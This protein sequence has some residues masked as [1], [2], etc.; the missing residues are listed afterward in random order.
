MISKKPTAI[1]IGAGFTGIATAYDLAMRGFT[2]DVLERGELG[3]GTS[4][5][6]HGLLH[7]GAR[8]CVHDQESA[9]ECIVENN[10]LRKIARQCIEA[11]A[12]YFIALNES[13]EE[14]AELFIR[15]ARDCALPYKEVTPKGLLMVEPQVTP[16]IRRAFCVQD[17]TFDPLRLTY[18]FAA[19]ARKFGAK[20]HPYNE[21]EELIQDQTKRVIAAK[22]WDRVTDTHLDY[23][24]DVWIN[25]AGAWA[26]KIASMAGIDLPVKPVPGVMVAVEKRLC[27][28]TI[29]RLNEPGDGDIILP[30]RRMVVIGTTSFEATDVDYIP[31]L[32]EQV[33]QMVAQG[34]EMIPAIRTTGYRGIFMSSRPLVKAEGEARNLARTFKVYDH[35]S[36]D[37]VYGLFSMIGG[38][39]TTCR[40]MAEKIADVV[41]SKFQLDI[42]C[43]TAEN[44][45]ESYR[46]F[47]QSG[48]EIA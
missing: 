47:Y 41:T 27:Q 39:A 8:Y 15:G 34:S 16:D 46:K 37:G 20:F 48:P 38:K 44:E 5:R 11:N 4:G 2:V 9:I 10:I 6:T 29:N 19:S 12:G 7:S 33:D 30:Q 25:T 45:L 32:R 13:D 40:A 31:I 26:G 24:A 17:G 28:N 22:V 3:S 23:H 21:V 42:P 36:T 18:A 35:E 1:I 14:Y 43:R